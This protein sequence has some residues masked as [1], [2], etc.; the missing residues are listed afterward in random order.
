MTSK[1]VLSSRPAQAAGAKLSLAGVIAIAIAS[2]GLVANAA[3]IAEWMV[4]PASDTRSSDA[5][6]PADDDPSS[7]SRTSLGLQG[8]VARQPVYGYAASHDGGSSATVT[9]EIVHAACVDGEF[10]ADDSGALVEIYGES[11]TSSTTVHTHIYLALCV[12]PPSC[13]GTAVNAVGTHPESARSR[14]SNT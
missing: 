1:R 11:T 8:V 4:R 10:V 14:N 3:T 2:V 12:G 6:W 5:V 13:W 7:G 9:V